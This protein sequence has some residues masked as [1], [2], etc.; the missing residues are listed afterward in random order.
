MSGITETSGMARS[1]AEAVASV[2]AGRGSEKGGGA[3]ADSAY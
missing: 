3:H 1:L 2:L